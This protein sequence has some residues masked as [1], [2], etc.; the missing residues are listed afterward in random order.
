MFPEE[1]PRPRRGGKAPSQ[2]TGLIGRRCTHGN[3]F[4]RPVLIGRGL[5]HPPTPRH[6]GGRAGDHPHPAAARLLVSRPL[7]ESRHATT[8]HPRPKGGG[9]G[10]VMVVCRAVF[11]WS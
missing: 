10:L 9:V 7:C 2:T 8:P 1:V 6:C 3:V 11:R 4:S 5:T